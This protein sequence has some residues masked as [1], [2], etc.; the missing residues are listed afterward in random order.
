MV[1]RRLADT[2]SYQAGMPSCH[3]FVVGV[4]LEQLFPS[5][6]LTVISVPNLEP[7]R[8]SWQ[9]R[10]ELALG[11]NTFQ[12]MFA[13]QT[14]QSLAISVNMIAVDQPFAT[15]WHNRAQPHL[16]VDQCQVSQVLAINP[17]Q[18]EGDKPRLT[19]SEQEITALWFA[20]S[21]QANDLAIE[22]S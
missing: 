15:L 22:H 18:I 10:V 16:A 3:W 1:L 20:F 19:S 17:Q 21:V 12:V 4:V 9:V 5:S 7:T 11:N 6:P 14:E 2:A 13:D 8:L